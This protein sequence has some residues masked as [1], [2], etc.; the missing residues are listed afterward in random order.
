MAQYLE[1]V[2]RAGERWDLIAW[3]YYGDPSL[4]GQLVLANPAV[5][6]EPVLEAGIRLQIPVV[7]KSV[8]MTAGLPPWKRRP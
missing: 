1:H 7:Q 4:Y 8:T 3:T 6:V 5:A 2:T